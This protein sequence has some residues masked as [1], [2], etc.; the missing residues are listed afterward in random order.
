MG[1]DIH[2]TYE[3]KDKKDN[4]KELE[5]D[6]DYGS[7]YY[8][9]RNYMLF[10]VLADVRNGVGF[11]GVPTYDPIEAI[12]MPRGLPRDISVVNID[13]DDSEYPF[14]DDENYRYGD[15]SQSWLT[16]TEIL[17]YFK[18]P[19]TTTRH[20][21]INKDSYIKWDGVIQPDIW[22][23]GIS[24]PDVEIFD[25]QGIAG[26]LIP[27]KYSHVNISWVI[28]IAQELKYFVDGIRELEEQFGEIR[29]VFG[30]DS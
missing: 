7:R 4:W 12:A 29:L 28:D 2:F 14:G 26:T 15:H 11:A 27:D 9:G 17:E 24:G 6:Y 22:C 21:I 16:S 20:G 23:G 8:I 25:V 19:R 30:F 10:S 5:M 18:S 3:S 1:T 13:T